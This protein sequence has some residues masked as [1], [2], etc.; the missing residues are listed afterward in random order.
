MLDPWPASRGGRIRASTPGCHDRSQDRRLPKAGGQVPRGGHEGA[1][2]D[3]LDPRG[4]GG[5]GGRPGERLRSPAPARGNEAR[6]RGP[7]GAGQGAPPG[8][9]PAGLPARRER[10]GHRGALQ[11]RAGRLKGG[12]C[13]PGRALGGPGLRGGLPPAPG[14][15]RGGVEVRPRAAANGLHEAGR[16]PAEHPPAS[17]GRPRNHRPAGALEPREEFPPGGTPG[18]GAPRHVRPLLR[19]GDHPVGERPAN[20]PGPGPGHGPAHQGG[21]GHEPERAPRPATRTRPSGA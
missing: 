6:R 7:V 12:E 13:L 18:T 19:R 11:P 21:G 8:D 4:G 14:E 1:G 16:Q 5:A 3:D 15:R 2:A 9:P 17:E 10:A 20:S